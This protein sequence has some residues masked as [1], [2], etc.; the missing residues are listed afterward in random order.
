MWPLS[1][2]RV[3]L[4]L[5]SGVLV[6]CAAVVVLPL[7]SDIYWAFELPGH[8]RAQFAVVALLTTL[9][10]VVVRAWQHAV[11]GFILC[12]VIAGPVLFLWVPSRS[13][14]ES[15]STLDVLSLNVSLYGRNAEV[16]GQLIQRLEPDIVGLVEVDREW[17]KDLGS[18]DDA[19]PY[20]LVEPPGRRAG[21]AL[22][23]KFPL[24][25]PEIRPLADTR[26]LAASVRL[27]RHVV[28]VGVV[29]TASPLGRERAALRDQQLTALSVLGNRDPSRDLVL[30]GDFNTSP[31]SL[32]FRRLTTQTGLR[33]AAAGFGYHPT[34]PV[35]WPLIGIPIDHYLVS[36][37]ISVREFAT[38]GPTGSD[39][40]AIH[41]RLA[42][43]A[44]P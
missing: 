27:D 15:E 1:L 34:W 24:G 7:L 38:V 17:V 13:S 33:D 14:D 9:G 6:A 40:L 26:L 25:A 12:A 29:H 19:Y 16:V 42:L 30:M 43:R 21:A 35:R 31:W 32:A 22:L 3:V 41:A 37:G 5:L 8:F 4:R 39:H 36:D 44:G 20:R 10:L 2:R 18:L 11:L 28:A 23:S